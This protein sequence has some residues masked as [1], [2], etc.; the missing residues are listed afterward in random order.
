MSYDRLAEMRTRRNNIRRYR[1]L[2]ST[3]LTEL[4]R[5]YI[6]RRLAEEYSAFD[7]LMASTLPMTFTMPPDGAPWAQ[8]RPEP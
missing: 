5:D 2:L 1:R 3:E 8:A 4:E 7:G 6:Q